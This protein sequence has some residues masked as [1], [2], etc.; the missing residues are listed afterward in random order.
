MADRGARFRSLRVRIVGAF[1]LALGVAVLAQLVLLRGQQ[2]ISQALILI[3]EGYLPLN[4]VTVRLERDYQRVDRDLTRLAK[5]RVRAATATSATTV[6]IEGMRE[7]VQVAQLLL[8]GA[9]DLAE[10]PE[11]VA[12]LRRIDSHL[13]KLLAAADRYEELAAAYQTAELTPGEA[14]DLR[15]TLRQEGHR[16]G[17]EIAALDRVLAA[18]VRTLVE[19][20]E[21]GQR[22]SSAVS[23]GLTS[24]SVVLGLVLLMAILHAL[25]PVRRLTAE[26]G[27]IAE[28]DYGGRVAVGGSDEI[29][30]LAQEFNKMAEAVQLRDRRLVDRAAELDRTQRELASV[31]D[32]IEDTLLVVRAGLIVRANPAASRDFGAEQGQAV[33]SELQDAIQPGSRNLRDD[34]GRLWQVRAAALGDGDV[35]AIAA[36]VTAEADAAERLARSERLAMIGQMLAQITHEV[37]NPL[38]ALSLNAE[39]L[40]DELGDL[41]P[42]RETEAWDILALVTREIERLTDLTGHYLQLAR[43]PVASLETVELSEMIEDVLRLLAVEAERSGVELVAELEHDL[44]AQADGNQLRQAVHNVV[45]NAM[46]AGA[47]RVEVELL[48]EDDEIAIRVTDDGAGMTDAEVARACDPFFST[49]ADG[50][51]LGLAIT[52]QILEDHHGRLAVASK[53]GAGTEV[54]FYLPG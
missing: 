15:R 5:A 45:R 22:R 42:A 4:G 29:A 54:T 2:P 17:Q 33:P 26:V 53:P 25:S 3:S 35:V 1:L 48:R 30:D 18:R 49:K 19:G 20:V 44:V 47:K 51:G 11:E 38:N 34:A 24:I 16:M 14:A 9:K 28:G 46:Q 27:R 41:D 37:R 32:A 39:L 50:S 52:R 23:L 12:V 10:D 36:D 6:G 21:Q 13:S 43:R 8:G 31:L 7:N 40:S